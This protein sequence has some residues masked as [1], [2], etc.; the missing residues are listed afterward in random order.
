MRLEALLNLSCGTVSSVAPAGIAWRRDKEVR[1]SQTCVHDMDRRWCAY[2]TRTGGG[3]SGSRKAAPTERGR[4][5]QE[6]LDLLCDQ[7]GITRRA[8][9]V[10]S[11]LPSEVFEALRRRFRVGGRSMPEVAEG[12]VRRAGLAWSSNFDSRGTLS[13][14]GSTVTRD[15]LAQVNKAVATLLATGARPSKPST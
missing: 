5:K 7:L 13:G 8:V 6:E 12:V 4:S 1:L 14:G 9:G 11:S 15:G 3:D 2:C 10:G